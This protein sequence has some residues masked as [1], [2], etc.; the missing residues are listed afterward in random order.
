MVRD[1]IQ[2]DARLRDLLQKVTIA[3]TDLSG[4]EKQ[5]LGID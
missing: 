5:D 4:Q 3:A 1:G 2:V